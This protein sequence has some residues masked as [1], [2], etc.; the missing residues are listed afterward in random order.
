MHTVG[1]F[2]NTKVLHQTLNLTAE[3]WCET[4]SRIKVDMVLH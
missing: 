2:R 1:H 3:L 4:L